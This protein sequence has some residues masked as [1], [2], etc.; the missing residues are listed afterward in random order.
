M[1][2]I[3]AR[4]ENG[5][6]LVDQPTSLPEGTV[7]DLV[8]DDEGDALDASEREMLDA[9]ISAAWQS[10]REGRGRAAADVLADLRRR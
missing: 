10:V 3:R 8:V 4:V 6:L 5:R 9:A 1:S 7:L 2:A